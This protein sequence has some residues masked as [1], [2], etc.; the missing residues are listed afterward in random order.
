MHTVKGAVNQD[1]SGVVTVYVSF[2]MGVFE[3][4]KCL[5]KQ[6]RKSNYILGER[7]EVATGIN[8]QFSYIVK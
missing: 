2:S 4:K 1:S 3:G 6:N 5:A 8:G 7:T